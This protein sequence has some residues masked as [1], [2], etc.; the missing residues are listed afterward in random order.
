VSAR[1][2]SH[3]GIEVTLIPGSGGAFEIVDDGQLKYSKLKLGRF[4]TDDEVDQI[5]G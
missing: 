4:P 3:P 2:E 1:I 5:V